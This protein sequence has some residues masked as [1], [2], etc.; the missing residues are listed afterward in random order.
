MAE[1]GFSGRLLRDAAEVLVLVHK[2][3]RASRNAR[4]LWLFENLNKGV[5]IDTSLVG[6]FSLCLKL[7]RL[8][9][10]ERRRWVEEVGFKQA[11]LEKLL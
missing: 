9:K 5:T 1:G 11:V 4:A 2:S 10:E 8:H 7:G 6:I 3:F